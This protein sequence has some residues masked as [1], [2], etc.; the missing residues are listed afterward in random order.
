M[1][2]TFEPISLDRQAAYREAFGR[3]PGKASDYSFVNLWGWGAHYGLQWAW[4]DG[5]VWLRQSR[6]QPAY[7]APV[8]P[9]PPGDWPA[10][11]AR[12]LE[13]EARLVRVPEE[14][15]RIWAEALGDRVRVSPTPDQWDY[16]YER[17]ALA[18]LKGNRFHKKKN[19]VNQFR[20]S[21]AFEYVPFSEGIV[22]EALALQDTWCAWRDCE[23]SGTLAAENDAIEKVL[24]HWRTLTGL[25]GGALRVDGRMI[26]YT[27]AEALDAQTLVIHFEKAD[28]DY[29]GAYQ[30]INQMFLAQAAGAFSVVNREQDLGDDGLRKAKLSYHPVGYL[31]KAEVRLAAPADPS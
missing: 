3:T 4:S 1:P 19:L 31:K 10:V 6:P 23:S 18:E 15:A 28:P 5:R 20:K 7:W 8:G 16:L 22:D 17:Q 9:W 14:L 21:Y 13:S 12:E 2:L 29:K 24:T 27:I 25:V 30:A 26:A 11:L